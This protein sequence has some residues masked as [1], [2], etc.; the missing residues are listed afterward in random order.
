MY[1]FAEEDIE[2]AIEP[3]LSASGLHRQPNEEI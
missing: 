3:P 2:D 1:A